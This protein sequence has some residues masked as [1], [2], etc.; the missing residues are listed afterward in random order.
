MKIANAA[1]MADIDARTA[2]EWGV[3]SALLM[4]NAGRAAAYAVAGRWPCERRI[5]VLCGPGNNG[6]DGFCVAR[7]LSNLGYGVLCFSGADPGRYGADAAAQRNAWLLSGGE[8]QPLEQLPLRLRDDDVAVD[9]LFGTGLQRPL[10][11]VYAQAVELLQRRKIETAAVDIPSG[12]SCDTGRVLGAA[13]KC[14]LTV[15]MGLPKPGLFIYPG[16]DLSGEI[17]VAELGFARRLLENENLEGEIITSSLA[18]SWLRSPQP[19]AHKGSQG[20]ALIVGGSAWYYGAPLLAAEAALRAGAGLCLWATPDRLV[21]HR[22]FEFREIMVWPLPAPQGVIGAEAWPE[23]SGGL[24]NRRGGVSGRLLPH[25]SAVCV[26]PGLGR[27]ET[28]S[29][30]IKNVLDHTEIPVVLDADALHALGGLTLSERVVLTPHRGEMAA[31]LEC[32]A[33][34]IESDL[35]AAVKR[36]A[37]RYHAVVVLKGTPTLIGYRG[38]YWLLDAPNPVLAQGGTGDVLAGIITALLAQGYAPHEAAVLGVYLHSQAGLLAA[39]RIGPRGVLAGEAAA[40]LP[41][42]FAELAK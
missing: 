35:V 32:S 8:I 39:E 26:G 1:Q 31:L 4:E 42:V 28:A 34:D 22:P 41:K 14:V 36:A 23:L 21:E 33:E 16:K 25:I 37:A 2:Q 9:A 11:G 6:G 29:Q 38:K 5:V 17:V 3:S 19:W 40:L 15:T 24:L 30:L 12:V 18:R 27:G 20:C 7:T 13:P 10:T